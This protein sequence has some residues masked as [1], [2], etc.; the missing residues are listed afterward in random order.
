MMSRFLL[1]TALLSALAATALASNKT[2]TTTT[3]TTTTTTTTTTHVCATSPCVPGRSVCVEDGLDYVCECANGYTAHEGHVGIDGSGCGKVMVKSES[4][5]LH[6]EVPA[7]KDIR[8]FQA[9]GEI[10]SIN[11]IID[12]S[13][14]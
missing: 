14:R 1:L 12:D 4:A 10:T 6:L 3:S 7:G 13:K 5:D 9:A 2:T 11:K 8:F